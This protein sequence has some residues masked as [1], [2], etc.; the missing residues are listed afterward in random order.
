[1][2]QQNANLEIL[3]ILAQLVKNHPELRFHQLL[4]TYG[5]ISN[6]RD[7]FYESSFSTL[8]HLQEGSE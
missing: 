8:K 4:F 6:G 7:K 2:D 5:V 1:M 3:W